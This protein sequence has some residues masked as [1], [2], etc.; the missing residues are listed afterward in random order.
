ML[1]DIGLNIR[2]AHVFS[3]IDG[4]SLDVFV[5]DGWPTEVNYINR[6]ANHCNLVNLAEKLLYVFGDHS[7]IDWSLH[8]LSIE[9]IYYYYI[10]IRSGGNICKNARVSARIFHQILS[11]S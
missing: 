10:F 1:A 3:T 9:L 11:V 4:F 8:P 6:T 5:V 7:T 2:E